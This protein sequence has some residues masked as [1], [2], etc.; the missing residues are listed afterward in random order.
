MITHVIGPLVF[1]L[2]AARYR[3]IS[4]LDALTTTAAVASPL[5]FLWLAGRWHLASVW[6]RY[7]LPF[8]V[9][10]VAA[11]SWRR[12]RGLPLYASNGAR[13]WILRTVKVALI[14]YV[15]GQT[16]VALAGRRAREETVALNFPL[17]DGWFYVGQG[18][19]TATVNYHVVNRTQRYALDI[20]ALS[21]WGNRGVRFR[22]RSLKEYSSYGRP[23]YA[24]CNGRV[25]YVESSLRDN[26][27][28]SDRDRERPAGNQ[29]VL[30]C[31]DTDVDILMAHLQNGSVRVRINEQ[32]QVGT[33]LGAI[34][35][36]GNSTEP[37]LHIHA[38]RG[39]SPRSGLTGEGVP[40]AFSGRFLTRNAIIHQRRSK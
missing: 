20:V 7:A 35:N 11:V 30:R 24:P 26:V 14:L 27:T 1:L 2:L 38:K 5:I 4:R 40:M 13:T 8:A 32:I 21:A 18:G 23:V 16:A 3:P 19:S 34:G 10:A 39:G 33:R 31:V 15:S 37:H 12:G 28:P 36:S 22:P 25:E 29:I 6:L 17:D 9:V